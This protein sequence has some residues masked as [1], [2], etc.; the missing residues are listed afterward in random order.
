MLRLCYTYL[1]YY[2]IFVM[3]LVLSFGCMY[4]IS[5][6]MDPNAFSAL[7]LVK[8]TVNSQLFLGSCNQSF[9]PQIPS[10]FCCCSWFVTI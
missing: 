4:P 10:C 9:N 2:C 1:S 8:Y 7:K 5:A 3:L 6:V